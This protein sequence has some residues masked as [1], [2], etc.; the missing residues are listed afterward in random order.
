MND[1]PELRPRDRGALARIALA[2]AAA[3]TLDLAYAFAINAAAG[4][5]PL[6]VLQFIGSG[7]LGRA[8]FSGGTGSA[9][10]GAVA[11]YAIMGGFAA[12]VAAFAGRRISSSLQP[13]IIGFVA[14][15]G[16]YV[17]MTYL[18]TPLSRVPALP[19]MPPARTVLEF[20]MH[21]VV[22]GPLVALIVLGRRD[23][24]APVVIWRRP[25]AN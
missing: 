19:P 7:L 12:A 13:P 16:L 11:H 21:A 14:G 5:R 22:L 6:T 20:A 1:S 25:S 18:V 4:V 15:A 9:V 17:V 2:A 23:A 3:G 24:N 8:A 10:V